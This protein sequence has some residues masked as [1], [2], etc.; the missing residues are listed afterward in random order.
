MEG[1]APKKIGVDRMMDHFWWE[2][3]DTIWL[4]NIAMENPP[5][6]KNGKLS[7]S[8]GHLY[9]GKLWMS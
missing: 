4:F 7:I 8:M 5:I 9:H 3:N 2:K 1:K 6:F